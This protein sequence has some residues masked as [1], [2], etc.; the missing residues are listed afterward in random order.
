MFHSHCSVF[1]ACIFQQTNVE[2]SKFLHFY[3]C[4]HHHRSFN[5]EMQNELDSNVVCQKAFNL[6]FQ[7]FLCL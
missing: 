7:N 5:F 3:H 6:C 4:L 1:S 2:N